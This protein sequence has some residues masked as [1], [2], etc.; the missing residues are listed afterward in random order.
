MKKYTILFC[1][2]SPF[3]IIQVFSQNKDNI[4]LNSILKNQK[5]YFNRLPEQDKNFYVS[6]I[7]LAKWIRPK[8]IAKI[9]SLDSPFDSPYSKL[10]IIEG[11]DFAHGNIYGLIW[12][13]SVYY[14]YI[15]NPSKIAGSDLSIEK[16]FFSQLNEE[17]KEISSNFDDWHNKIFRS[18]K[19]SPRHVNPPLYYLASK[20]YRSSK[21]IKTIAFCY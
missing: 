9:D 6:I 19:I 3:F 8:V 18:F 21:K 5:D 7:N 10:N 20:M 4:L 15:N 12:V 2:L 14:E 11:Y 16:K 17:E 13:D 1:L